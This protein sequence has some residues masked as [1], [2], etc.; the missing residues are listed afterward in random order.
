MSS[1]RRRVSA[2]AVITSQLPSRVLASA[3]LTDGGWAAAT[4]DEVAV[5]PADG[6]VFRAPWTAVAHGSLDADTREVTLSWADGAPDTVIPLAEGAEG[7]F[8]EVL[9]ERVHASLVH[10]ETIRLPGGGS[11]MVALRTDGDQVFSQVIAPGADL[12]D[13]EVSALVGTAVARVREVA[14]LPRQML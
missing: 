14:G 11:A 4:R 2:P 5:F 9:R 8:P 7:R 12:T 6:E 10:S 3:E 1:R 13:P